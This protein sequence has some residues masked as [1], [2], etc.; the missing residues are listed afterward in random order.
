VRSDAEKYL[1]L[2]AFNLVECIAATA[3]GGTPQRRPASRKQAAP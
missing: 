3:P 1:L 2:A